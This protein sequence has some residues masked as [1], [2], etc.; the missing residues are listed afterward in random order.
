MSSGSP[1]CFGAF[2]LNL[3]TGEIRKSGRV[4]Q[5]SPQPFRLLAL[6]AS[7]PGQLMTRDA[8]RR[9]LWGNNSLIDFEGRLNFCVRKIRIVLGDNSKRPRYIETLPRRGYRFVAKSSTHPQ[10]PPAGSRRNGV[11]SD[12]P[13]AGGVTSSEDARQAIAIVEFLNVSGDPDIDWLATGMAETL[14]ADLR[15]L[16]SVWVVSPDRVRATTVK[17]G[18]LA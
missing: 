11:P 4:V 1:I 8:I 13:V 5:L 3:V 18:Q 16:P 7:A 14:A 12:R 2:E 17:L 6:L 15:R 9:E 10:G